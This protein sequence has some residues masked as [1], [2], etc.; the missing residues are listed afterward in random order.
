MSLN[1]DPRRYEHLSRIRLED[2][3]A[4]ARAAATR[5]RHPGLKHGDKLGGDLF[6]VAW[7]PESHPAASR[8]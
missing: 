7:P 5:L 6:P 1:D 8:G 4:V 3:Q 2:P